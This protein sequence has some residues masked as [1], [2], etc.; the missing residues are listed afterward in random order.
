[1]ETP[2]DSLQTFSGQEV[3]GTPEIVLSRI[4][5]EAEAIFERRGVPREFGKRGNFCGFASDLVKRAAERGGIETTQTRQ[6]LSVH[7]EF[8]NTDDR[9]ALQHA[10][11][12]LKIGENAYLV[13]L[14]FCQF[15]DPKTGEIRQANIKGGGSAEDYPQLSQLMRNGFIVLTDGSLREYLKMTTSATDK[16]YIDSATVD[17]LLAQKSLEYD[18]DEEELDEFLDGT[19]I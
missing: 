14:S 8:G 17:K 12:T 3:L 18:H 13:D 9:S 19:R 10:F 5:A 15:V 4:I 16:S 7:R 1:M 6:L 11:N 2:E